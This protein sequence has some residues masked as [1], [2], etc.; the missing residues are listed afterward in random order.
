MAIQTIT[1]DNKVAL[2]TNPEI[3]DINK[4]NASDMNEIKNIVNNNA[5]NIGDLANL[6]TSDTSSLVDSINSLT[7][8]VLF[9]NTSGS[10]GN[11]TLSDNLTNYKKIDIEFKLE[12][13]YFVNSS[14]NPNGKKI[15]IFCSYLNDANF[16]QITG[17]NLFASGNEI[18]RGSRFYVNI[19]SSAAVQVG[20]A[21]G[22]TPITKV[23]GYK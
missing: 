11:I 15:P 18:T 8:K 13:K 20:T 17:E 16:Y 2:N 3:A 12:N 5:N 23:I 9:E 6:E 19:S 7:P 1:Y 21:R 4:C 10:G 14:Y 22:S